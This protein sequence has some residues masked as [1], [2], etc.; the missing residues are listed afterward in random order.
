MTRAA[1][2]LGDPKAP[3]GVPIDGVLFDLD[4]V[5]YHGPDAVPGAVDGITDL[6]ERGIP[7]GYVTNNAT[8]T[9]EAVARHICGLGIPT[10]PNQVITSAQVLASRLAEEYGRGAR[11][12]LL[13][14]TGLREA[15]AEA[16]LEVVGSLEDSPVALAQGLDPAIDY[17]KIVAAAEAIT[18]GLDWWASN[19]DYSMVGRASRV[20]GNGA[21][22]DMLSRLTGRQPHVVGKPSPDVVTHAAHRL[23]ARR[24]LMVGDRLDTDIAGGNRAGFDTA[25]VLTGVHDLHDALAADPLHRPTFVLAALDD[26]PR[27]L[28]AATAPDDVATTPDDV[29]TTPDDTA[30]ATSA[31]RFGEQDTGRRRAA[32]PS[33]RAAGH[34]S[35]ATDDS[36]RAPVSRTNQGQAARGSNSAPEP[37]ENPVR[38]VDGVLDL[39][40]AAGTDAAVVETAL[41]TAWKAIDAGES[42]EP[43]NLPRRIDD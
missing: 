36:G 10:E 33:E 18:A 21:F 19:P 8:R 16:G 14:A 38:I 5:V 35:A 37:R 24:P 41:R 39:D 23:G 26:L 34:G 31:A 40:E 17:A 1:E 12:L 22:V 9:A 2:H 20:P 7:V 15:L 43:G 6:H 42:I 27:V 28:D 30:T 3:A 13:G 29:A 25:L 4:G 11:I 32:H